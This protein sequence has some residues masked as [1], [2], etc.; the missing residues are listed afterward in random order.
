MDAVVRYQVL[1]LLKPIAVMA[2]LFISGHATAQPPQFAVAEA[3]Y[4]DLPVE[5]R[6]DGVVEAV[7]K[8]TISARTS[9][10]IIELPFDVNDYVPKDA[11][12][13]RFDDTEQKARLDKAIAAEAQA[14][15]RLAEAQ[16]RHER[17]Q[18]LARE[19]ATSKAELEKSAADL[20]SASA[21][22]ESARAALNEAREQWEYTVVRAPYAGVLVERL[23]ELGEHVQPGKPLGTGLSLERLRIEVQLPARFVHSVRENGLARIL[24]PDGENGW[25]ESEKVTVFPYADPRSHTFTV[26]LDLPQGQHG[27]YPGMFV[28]V[29][30]TVGKQRQLVIP[31]EAVVYRS[32]VTGVYV[33]DT[34]KQVR[35]RQIRVGRD[36]A[37]TLK[38]VLSGLQEGETV[39]LDPVAAG[40]ALKRQQAAPRP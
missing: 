40:I 4:Q 16:S 31:A 37:D 11:V 5:Q 25:L 3:R 12:V 29:A 36:V 38:V 34:D 9:G 28:K 10:E 1:R 7:H 15:A 20:K 33:V 13:V 26:R 22:L 19:G 6:F 8:S 23:V 32:E 35:L 39:A 14:Q 18:R 27:L 17:N 21:A 24:L 30:F 2:C